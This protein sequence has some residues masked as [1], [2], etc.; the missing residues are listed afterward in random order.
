MPRPHEPSSS[1][2]SP[3]PERGPETTSAEADSLGHGLR[4][5]GPTGV[6]AILV[7]LLA[8]NLGPIP[9]G[10][11]LALLWARMTRTPLREFGYVRPASWARTAVT[12][13]L[14]GVAFKFAMKALV[15]PLLGADPVNQAYH[16][17]AGNPAALPGAVLTMIVAAGFGEETVYR[18]FL[19]ERF[20]RLLGRGALARGIAVLVSSALFGLAHYPTQGLTGVEQAAIVGLAYGTV[21]AVSG[22][23]AVLMIT[24][25]A[26]DLAAVAIIYL[27]LESKVA[28]FFFH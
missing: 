28:H 5:F 17:L 20:G 24:H 4:G 18:G 19:F 14:C 3:A 1:P 25:A 12:G 27:N 21:F 15:M 26:F 6:F 2:A 10:G 13:I 9:A 11:L 7:V 22:Q 23:I 8:G 16:Y